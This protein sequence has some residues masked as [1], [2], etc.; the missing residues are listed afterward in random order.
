[1]IWI[2]YNLLKI[3]SPIFLQNAVD[4]LG[5]SIKTVEI[6]VIFHS[7]YIAQD[8]K[9]TG[10]CF[11]SPISAEKKKIDLPTNFP[12]NYE[13]M[14]CQPGNKEAKCLRLESVTADNLL[15]CTFVRNLNW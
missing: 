9:R 3:F 15:K 6:S 12:K 1:M 14:I 13:I 4:P 11:I 2:N 10:I 5:F 7:A 8:L